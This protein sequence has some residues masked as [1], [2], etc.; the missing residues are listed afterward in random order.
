MKISNE[1]ELQKITFNHS[2]DI[3]SKD[4]MN[5]YKHF[6]AK[7]YSLLVIDTTLA[8]D[9]RTRFRNNI[10]ERIQELFMT[11][12][13]KIK[14]E[15]LQ[16]DINREAAKISALFSCKTD[17]YAYL[18]GEKILHSNQIQIIEHTKLAYSLLGKTFEKQTEKQ[19]DAIKSLKAF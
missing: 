17:K 2:S 19:V 1:E 12:D 13:D 16:Y 14:D 6:T 9:N 10:L 5:L 8:S 11:I 18:T 7:P 15:N 3:D 4:F